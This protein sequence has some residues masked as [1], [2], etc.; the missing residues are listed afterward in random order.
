MGYGNIELF[1]EWEDGAMDGPRYHRPGMQGWYADADES[2]NEYSYIWKQMSRRTNN[3]GF[4]TTLQATGDNLNGDGIAFKDISGASRIDGPTFRERILKGVKHFPTASM[5]RKVDLSGVSREEKNFSAGTSAED[6]LILR[7]IILS[8]A[9]L[10]GTTED[11]GC[12]F[13]NADYVGANFAGADLTFA[14]FSGAILRDCVFDDANLT[15]VNF[16]GAN[17]I[18]TDLRKAIIDGIK[19]NSN[20]QFRETGVDTTE[21]AGKPK[22]SD[23]PDLGSA[24]P[25]YSQQLIDYNNLSAK[26]G[27]FTHVFPENALPNRYIVSETNFDDTLKSGGDIVVNTAVGTR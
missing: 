24:D 5:A 23:Y 6:R 20:T 8:E 11:D 4:D 21:T 12:Q 1:N 16:D 3:C 10:S 22:L 14:N 27:D 17:L 18:G 15:N 19:I 25:N 13:V 7:G 26:I 9:K 2:T